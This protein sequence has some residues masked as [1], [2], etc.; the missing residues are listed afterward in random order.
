MR[1]EVAIVI[2][3]S[4]LILFLYLHCSIL[5]IT[6]WP[7]RITHK[8]TPKTSAS[9]LVFDKQ[10]PVRSEQV[11]YPLR[12]FVYLPG[13]N[14]NPA[15]YALRGIVITFLMPGTIRGWNYLARANFSYLLLST[16][17]LASST[18][19]TFSVSS[20]TSVFSSATSSFKVFFSA[21]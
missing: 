17:S 12:S 8:I 6:I 5:I 10:L 7:C 2:A 4:I 14:E 9:F 1:I 15:R 21:A 11:A 18:S 19:S 13:K 16:A 20:S 3:T